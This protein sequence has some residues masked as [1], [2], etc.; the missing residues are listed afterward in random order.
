[1]KKLF[2]PFVVCILIFAPAARAGYSCEE[3]VYTAC[4]A[5]YYLANGKCVTCNASVDPVTS[6][7]YI[8][9]NTAFRDN[10][11]TIKFPTRINLQ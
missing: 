8:D 6:K 2:L 4:V 1:M 7:C 11:G 10:A 3:P 5:P 9:P